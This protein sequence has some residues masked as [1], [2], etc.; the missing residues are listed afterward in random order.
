MGTD[1]AHHLGHA[2]W[3][4]PVLDKEDRIGAPLL[5]QGLKLREKRA[6]KLSEK[7]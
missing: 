7:L 6:V 5:A 1:E 4:H 3:L 2:L